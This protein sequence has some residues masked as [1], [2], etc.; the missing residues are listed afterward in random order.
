MKKLILIILLLFA[1]SSFAQ[2][3]TSK[4]EL[5]KNSVDGKYS[6]IKNKVTYQ[7]VSAGNMVL[8]LSMNALDI[9][10]SEYSL[11]RNQSDG[12]YSIA[13][14]KVSL[15]GID[16]GKIRVTIS[17]SLN[18]F[19]QLSV[20]LPDTIFMTVGQEYNIYWHNI[21]NRYDYQ[22]YRYQVT[23]D[24]GKTLSQGFRF[25]PSG[26]STL[27]LYLAIYNQSNYR[28]SYDST[29]LKVNAKLSSN[30]KVLLVG[31]S[32]T[33]D[34]TYTKE[35]KVLGDSNITFI[36]TS[37]VDTTYLHT[38]GAAEYLGNTG[39]NNTM[40]VAWTVPLTT[41][42]SF[43]ETDVKVWGS[44]GSPTVGAFH[45]YRTKTP[46]S[47]NGTGRADTSLVYMDSVHISSGDLNT[48]STKFYK[49]IWNSSY[50][51]PTGYYLYIF[52]HKQSGGNP[53]MKVWDSVTV[54]TPARLQM[55]Y[56]IAAS[57]PLADR[58]YFNANIYPVPPKLV[59]YYNE[60]NSGKSYQYFASNAASPFVKSGVLNISN[61]LT[62]NKLPNPDIVIFELGTNDLWWET[63]ATVDATINGTIFKYQDSLINAFK[64]A[65]PNAKIGI[66]YVHPPAYNQDGFA[67]TYTN[68]QKQTWQ[69]K[70]IVH[71]YNQL[72]FNKFK[73]GAV[74]RV[75]LLPYN[76]GID[77]EHNYDVTAT[78][79][80]ARNATTYLMQTN[81]VH[82]ATSGYLQ[83]ADYF[84][85]WICK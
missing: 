6:L 18:P 52:L 82:P 10:T 65:L 28:L 24:S 38:R 76:I 74:A 29:V 61:Y 85:G 71:R 43:R 7:G 1:G 67:Y 45:L 58:F 5:M 15:Y 21:I 13:I 81:G 19:D 4:W 84:W 54:L 25:T 46:A 30:K 63:D 69:F 47:W 53:R 32:L 48:D 35:L 2:V 33:A 12:K 36:G 14:N 80:N 9:D 49:I 51:V 72:L 60:G 64:A 83:M 73:N 59:N 55:G 77:T 62:V 8:P 39:Y 23:C 78:P 68:T 40:C 34:L 11:I 41:T 16:S 3:D 27:K 31:N 17:Y 42:T 22:N 56:S 44:A 79:Y 66:T 70:R 50:T 75:S 20:C 37:G 57:N 26:T